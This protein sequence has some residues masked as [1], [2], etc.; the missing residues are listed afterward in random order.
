MVLKTAPKEGIA[1]LS[2]VASDKEVQQLAARFSGG[3][4]VRMMNLIQQTMAGFTRNA[5][6][7]MDA[8]LCIVNL[9]QPELTL[10]AQALNARLTRIEDKIA[11]GAFAVVPAPGLQQS[12]PEEDDY[13]PMPDDADA[14]P[15]PEIPSAPVPSEAPAGFWMDVAAAVRREL[16]PTMMG[17]FASSDRAPVQGVLYGTELVLECANGFVAEAVNKPEILSVVAT[18]ASAKLGTQLRVKVVDR[19][20]KP[21]KTAQMERLLDFGRAHNDIVKIKE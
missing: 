6:R 9:C 18:K 16:P 20:A 21:Q 10:D 4:L 11:T 17:L 12:H 3:E 19:S 8:E 14:P 1:M 13:P 7:R 5:S 15:D 2:G